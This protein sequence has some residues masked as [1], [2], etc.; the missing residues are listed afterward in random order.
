M[1]VSGLLTFINIASV[2]AATKIQDIFTIAKLV[3]LMLIIIT[4]AVML[5]QGRS[6]NT[7]CLNTVKPH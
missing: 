3:A 5:A 6:Y 1:F 7:K 2:K 4:G